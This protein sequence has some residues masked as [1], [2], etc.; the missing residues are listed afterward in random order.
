MKVS[1]GDGSRFEFGFPRKGPLPHDGVHHVVDSVMAIAD[2]FWGR[3]AAGQTPDEIQALSHASGHPSAKRAGVPE[4]AIHALLQ[5]ERL[6]ECLEADAWG[7][8]SSD[9]A[10]FREVYA[11]ACTQS[12]VTPLPLDESAFACLRTAMQELVQQWA[13]GSYRFRFPA[14]D[15]GGY[16]T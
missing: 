12:R 1:R 14:A 13:A 3:I 2:G 10:T 8:G 4:A 6:V 11:T 16:S 9:L 15:D 5:T 7:G